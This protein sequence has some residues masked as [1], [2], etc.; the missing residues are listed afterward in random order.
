MEKTNLKSYREGEKQFVVFKIADEHFGVEIF[1]AREIVRPQAIT[2]VPNAPSFVLGVCNIRGQ[3]VPIVDLRERFNLGG[4][5]LEDERK[6]I[7]VDVEGNDIGIL[8]DEVTEVIWMPEDDIEPPP[9]IAGGIDREYLKGIGKAHG[10]LLVILDLEKI[11]SP[12][13]IQ[14]MESTDFR[15]EGSGY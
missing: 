11:L 4:E 10:K 9:S 12:K 3:I 1:Q 6:I 7:T 5:A 14:E 8:V 15:G 13:E 2:R